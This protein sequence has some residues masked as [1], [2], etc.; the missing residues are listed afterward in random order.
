MCCCLFALFDVSRSIHA[1]ET[2]SVR[3]KRR[4]LWEAMEMALPQ[5]FDRIDAY[6]ET[7]QLDA[8]LFRSQGRTILFRLSDHQAGE[9]QHMA[10][11][12]LIN[13]ITFEDSGD[14]GEWVLWFN[15]K[16]QATIDSHYETVRLS[17]PSAGGGQ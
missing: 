14:D 15:G 9:V 1:G 11:P 10:E 12:G 4:A 2:D 5:G 16:P 7:P 8:I 17:A 6:G 3:I 13:R